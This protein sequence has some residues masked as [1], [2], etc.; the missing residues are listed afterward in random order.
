MAKIVL[1]ILAALIVLALGCGGGDT[2][3]P[4]A[5]ERTLRGHLTDVKAAS[6]L[7]IESI[8]I[9]TETG[10]SFVVEGDSRIFG[11]F[12]PSHL[13]QHMLDGTMVTVKYHEDGGRLVLNDVVD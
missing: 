4:P 11:G 6:L 9:E 1:L 10:E 3:L 7:E 12:T 2:E 13:R 5:N 8:T